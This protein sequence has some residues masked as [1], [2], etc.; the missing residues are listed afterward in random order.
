M[1]FINKQHQENFLS[2]LYKNN[3]KKSDKQYLVNYYVAAV[4]EIFELIDLSDSENVT[5]PIYSLMDWDEEKGDHSPS[6]PGLTGTTR[7]L[8]EIGASLYNGFKCDLDQSFG[9]E[10]SQVVIQACKIR[11]GLTLPLSGGI[12]N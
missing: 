6:S 7:T 4:P 11:Y 2:F 10:F 5:N 1:Y 8:L 3:H 12:V 9:E